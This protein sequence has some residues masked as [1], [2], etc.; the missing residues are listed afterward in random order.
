VPALIRTIIE[1]QHPTGVEQGR[2]GLFQVMNAL[3]LPGKDGGVELYIVAI[4]RVDGDVSCRAC[5]SIILLSW[6]SPWMTSTP[7][8]EWPLSVRDYGRVR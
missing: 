4:A 2:R 5:S 3:P 1:H 7:N 6:K 8:F